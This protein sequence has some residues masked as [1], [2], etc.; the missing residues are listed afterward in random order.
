MTKKIYLKD[1]LKFKPYDKQVP[2]DLYYLRLANQINTQ[3]MVSF[4]DFG[5][6]S[7]YNPMVVKDLSCFLCS[8]FEDIISNS[9]IWPTFTSA[10]KKLYAKALPFYNLDDYD[11]EDI[12]HEDI[13]F[14]IWYFLNTIENDKF[15]SPDSF[16]LTETADKVMDILDD[17][18]EMAPEN[19]HLQ[20]FYHLDPNET[21]FYIARDLIDTILFKT[22]LFYPDTALLQQVKELDIMEEDPALENVMMLLNESR[23]ETIHN[24]RTRLLNFKGKDWAA[25]L[26]SEN[27]EISKDFKNLSPKIIGYF[28]Y[29]G[30]DD[31]NIFIEHI[32]SGKK[33]NLTKKS[34]ENPQMLNEIGSI[35]FMGIVKWKEEWWFSGVFFKQDYSADLVRDEKSSWQSRSIVNFLDHEEK[36]PN[37]LLLKQYQA[38]LDFNGG[39]PIAFMESHQIEGFI[40]GYTEY[41]NGSL[42]LSAQ[43]M[44]KALQ[45]EAIDG[46]FTEDK[47]FTEVSESGLV[48]FNP[49]S[50]VEIA[51]EVNSAFPLPNNPYF[52]IEESETDLMFLLASDDFSR[53][54]A[55]YCIDQFKN[56][57]PF[58]TFGQGLNLLPDIDFLLRFWKKNNYHNQPAI[59]Y[60]GSKS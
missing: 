1:W 10:H 44:E 29:K 30:Q 26:L 2:S 21:D 6:L 3:L 23:D 34:F 45:K 37:S 14:L 12:N 25:E 31:S 49:K 9:R 57:L 41:Y 56:L 16:F 35:I 50:G 48:F 28:F 18:W 32:A 19:H 11:E 20:Q 17:A 8:Y 58:F 39:L 24:S 43:E 55:V 59:T 36:D 33:F 60:T 15:Y 13:S 53:E 46:L 38:F 51:F 27:Q 4:R 52:N 42:N 54:L 47:D 7:D 5:L 22:Y 40:K